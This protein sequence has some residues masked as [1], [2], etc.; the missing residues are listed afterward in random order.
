MTSGG[1]SGE[2]MELMELMELGWGKLRHM[3]FC[4]K[5]DSCAWLY[6]EPRILLFIT[7]RQDKF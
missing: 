3:G 7:D 1:H 5:L 2:L 6:M 4:I